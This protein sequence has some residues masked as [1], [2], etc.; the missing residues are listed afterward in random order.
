MR[1]N[2]LLKL[3][4]W[5]DSNRRK[6]LIIR[7][8]RQ[9]GKSWLMKEEFAKK[10]YDDYIYISFDKEL[11]AKKIFAETKDPKILLERISLYKNKP[12][13][14]EKTLLIFDEIQ[15]CPEAIGSLKYFNEE[16]NE[17]HIVSAGSLL[18]TYLAKDTSFPVGKVNL[19]S[20]YPLTFDEF[21]EE[22]DEGMYKYYQSITSP[23]DYV[24]AFHDKMLEIFR[25]YLIVGGMPE[26]V[27]SW[28]SNKNPQEVLEIQKELV[29]I[30]E[31]DFLKHNNKISSGKILQVFRNIIPQLAKE[32]NE[33]FVYSILRKGARGREYE[34]AIEW[35]ITS[36]L[37]FKVNN[38]TTPEYPLK[39][40][41]QQ[42]IFK[43]FLL[44]VGL[45]KYMAGL[46][47]SSILLD[48][49]FNFKGQLMENYVLEQ[50]APQMDF[51]PNY[52][53]MGK[54]F[55]IDFIIQKESAVVPLEVKAG[56]NKRA[57]SFK[58]YIEKHNPKIAIRFSSNGYVKDGEITN[59][60]L[61]LA[62]KTME[63][64][65]LC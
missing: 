26:C 28:V 13:L 63:L 17:Y 46:D 23:E 50:L 41:E 15:D 61:Y 32:N 57:S 44:D 51:T 20:L 6:P 34:D 27:K 5:K 8:A 1:R 64:L 55:E 43:L 3:L 19:L 29:R 16:A 4:E 10:Y 9:V 24:E 56:L 58:R 42:N 36:G 59:I 48:D 35:L 39:T 62:S 11:E 14:S 21:L 53:A 33:K 54:D 65:K 60:P 52:Y 31:S 7:G 40:Y 22:V 25:K 12:I 2:A 49:A 38:I 37:S 47:N 45:L 30:Y 18:G